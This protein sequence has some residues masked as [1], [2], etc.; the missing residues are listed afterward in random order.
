M[1]LR[2]RLPHTSSELGR[3][4]GTPDDMEALEQYRE[5]TSDYKIELSDIDDH[6]LKTYLPA[7]SEMLINGIVVDVLERSLRTRNQF[8]GN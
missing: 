4:T 5:Q 1:N 2:E 8:R 6:I 7:E 3:L